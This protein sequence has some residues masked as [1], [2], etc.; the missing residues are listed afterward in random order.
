MFKAIGTIVVILTVGSAISFLPSYMFP[1]E[2]K[3]VRVVTN[4]ANQ[5]VKTDATAVNKVLDSK[6]SK[7]KNADTTTD[8]DCWRTDNRPMAYH[9][10]QAQNERDAQI[11]VARREIPIIPQAEVLADQHNWVTMAPVF[12]PLHVMV[13]PTDTIKPSAQSTLESTADG[14]FPEGL[15][16]VFQNDQTVIMK[17][18]ADRHMQMTE[19]GNL[20][21]LIGRRCMEGTCSEALPMGSD[22]VVCPG[23]GG[24]LQTWHNGRVV[25]DHV[26]T[27][28]AFSNG[29]GKYRLKIVA[30][31]FA[32]SV[33]DANPG[34]TIVKTKKS[35]ATL[36]TNSQE[37]NY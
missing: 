22:S 2:L 15:P 29:I 13:F 16:E 8:W 14:I 26:P 34:R 37:E 30:D 17:D 18:R 33:C 1:P 9:V 23:T 3:G 27:T 36:T 12:E 24:Y 28:I 32:R 7:C 6:T 25:I 19:P 20:F 10:A 21:E 5:D 35:V 11:A 31:E 4:H